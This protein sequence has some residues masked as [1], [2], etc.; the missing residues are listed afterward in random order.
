MA[1]LTAPDPTR[2]H[3]VVVGIEHYRHLG[4]K[5][6]AGAAADAMRFARWLRRRGVPS[7]NI[8]LLLTPMSTSWADLNEQA[9]ELDVEIKPVISRDQII[10]RLAPS[11]TAAEGDVLYV[12]WGGHG[13]LDRGDRRLLLCPDAS[14]TDPRCLDL[15]DLREY[16]TRPDVA[17]CRK[18]IYL[19]DACATFVQD[20]TRPAV[21]ALPRGHRTSVQQFM[22]LAAAAGQAATQR[23]TGRTGA[24]S[25]AVMDW[26]EKHSPGLDTDLDALVAHVKEHFTEYRTGRGGRQ[27]QTPVTLVIQPFGG[28]VEIRQGPATTASGGEPGGEPGGPAPKAGRGVG[29]GIRKAAVVWAGAAVLVAIAVIAAVALNGK[30]GGD[31]RNGQA[32][33]AVGRRRSRVRRPH[34]PPRPPPPPRPLRAARRRARRPR[35]APRRRRSRP[36][37]PRPRVPASRARAMG[38]PRTPHRPAKSRA[39]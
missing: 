32:A 27:L 34:L 39:S 11:R 9:E 28:D 25:T 15:M 14:D 20:Q 7:Q 13:L 1:E 31:G 6:L 35:R 3:A 18:Q 37:R 33:R 4:N 29:A 5:E 30:E 19:V 8:T 22:L 38:W 16:L 24:F 2:V 23:T 26:L 17:R 36:R 10:D 12:Y 21:L